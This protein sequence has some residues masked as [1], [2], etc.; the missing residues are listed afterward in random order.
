MSVMLCISV[1]IEHSARQARCNQ[2]LLSQNRG[3]MEAG[4][5]IAG[6]GSFVLPLGLALPP[7]IG[8]AGDRFPPYMPDAP[9]RARRIGDYPH[10]ASG[11]PTFQFCS[12]RNCRDKQH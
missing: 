3:S 6:D 10:I 8:L 9:S 7:I 11:R 2:G 12:Q 5:C 4:F 1:S